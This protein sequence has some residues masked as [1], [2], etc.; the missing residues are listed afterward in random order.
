MLTGTDLYRDIHV[1]ASAQ[2]SLALAQR[3]IV[4]HEAAPHDLPAEHPR[5][6][7]GLLPVD[8]VAP[9]AGQ[10]RRAICAR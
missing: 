4:L 1:D 10:D 2:R 3:L 9:H 8:A 5:Q 6:G 7:V